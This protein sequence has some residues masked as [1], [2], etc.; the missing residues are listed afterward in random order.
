MDHVI[1]SGCGIGAKMFTAKDAAIIQKRHPAM[2]VVFTGTEAECDKWVDIW[3]DEHAD[4]MTFA[5]KVRQLIAML[6]L[7]DAIAKAA[8]QAIVTMFVSAGDATNS[9]VI[10]FAELMAELDSKRKSSRN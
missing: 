1:L 2:N 5:E 10:E 6:R 9:D 8:L 7:N 4:T 3:A